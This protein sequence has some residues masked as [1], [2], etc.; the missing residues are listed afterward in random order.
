MD[1]T[2]QPTEDEQAFGINHWVYCSQHMK[3]HLT[4]W[5]S[6]SPR[7]KVGLGITGH[8]TEKAREAYD[9]CEAWGFQI[10]KPIPHV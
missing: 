8:G 4:G 9:K 7:D 10:Y 2:K 1:E 6:V 5:C 3:P